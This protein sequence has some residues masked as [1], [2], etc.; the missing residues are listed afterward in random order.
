MHLFVCSNAM[1]WMC[2]TAVKN[3]T[4]EVHTYIS[5][6][7]LTELADHIFV[8]RVLLIPIERFLYFCLWPTCRFEVDGA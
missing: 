4:Q 2:T 7:R 8:G 3:K 5:F 6:L 1:T